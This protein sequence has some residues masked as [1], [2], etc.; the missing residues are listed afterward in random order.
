MR[1]DSPATSSPLRL[2]CA[3]AARGRPAATSPAALRVRNRRRPTEWDAADRL[4]MGA[5]LLWAGCKSSAASLSRR[6]A[7]ECRPAN[8]L[9]GQA[10]DAD[11]ADLVLGDLRRG[12]ERRV[13]E[14]VR[15][16]LLELH[17]RHEERARPHRLRHVRPAHELAAPRL[18]PEARARREAEAPRVARVD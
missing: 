18:D 4:R 2:P 7:S 3:R 8:E 11:G 5:L 15:R 14:E 10:L 12:V 16:R 9:L 17:E 6:P 1:S 13:R